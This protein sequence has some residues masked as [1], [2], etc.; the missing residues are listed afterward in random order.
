[1]PTESARPTPPRQTPTDAT[2]GDRRLSEQQKDSLTN[3]PAA[4]KPGRGDELPD[5]KDVGEAG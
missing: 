3:E 4:P 1:M 5:P 2:A